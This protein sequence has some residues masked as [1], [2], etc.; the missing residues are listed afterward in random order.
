[1]R[2]L[3]VGLGVVVLIFV[4]LWV[5]LWA[6]FTPSKIV[7]FHPREF[8]AKADENFFYSIDG[9]LKYSDELNSR[10]PTLL[11]GEIKDFR[12]S[13]D[14]AKIAVVVSQHLVIV[15]KTTVRDVA[16]VD[17]IY[18]QP[19]PIGRHFYRDQGFQWSEDSRN[20]YL[21]RD[22][23]YES[24]GSQLF[25]SKGE[26]WKYDLDV[27][28]LQ[29][30]LKPFPAYTCFFGRNGEIYFSVPTES[31]D[32]QLKHFDGAR[33]NDV[34]R[35]NAWA[36]SSEQLL[37]NSV[38]SPFYSFTVHDYRMTTRSGKQVEFV[39]GQEGGPQ[40]LEVAKKPYL[41]VTEGEGIKGRFHCFD[42]S[43]SAF[44]PGDR[45]F[46]IGTYCG[47]YNG[48]LLVDTVTGSYQ[49]LAGKTRVYPLM[50]TKTY[51][52]YRITGGGMVPN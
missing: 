27:G 15:D 10:A 42:A 24:S 14:N 49:K 28:T 23:Y 12:V 52:Y 13:P 30:I 48:Q 17:S 46:L 40:R 25:S 29:P 38:E 9:A 33:V 5:Y 19:K 21:I 36:I 41:A 50:N 51:P 20:L 3:G 8:E 44:L 39:S 43:H 35:P 34:G 45:Y 4:S 26:L 22:E 2:Y 11:R 37:S 32:L 6:A 47:N 16:S 1:M 7:D 18:R 31:G